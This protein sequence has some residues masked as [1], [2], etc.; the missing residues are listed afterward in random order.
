MKRLRFQRLQ[1]IQQLDPWRDNCKIARLVAGYE[2]PWDMTKALEIAL[3]RTFC[4]P[5]ISHLLDKT[6]E[7]AVRSQ[8]RYDDTGLIVSSIFKWGHD[9]EQG[10][11]AIARMNRIHSHFPISNEDYLYVLSTFIYEP[12]RWIDRFGWRQLCEVEKQGLFYFWL[13]IGEQ[14]GLQRLPSTYEAFEQYNLAYEAEHFRYSAAAQRVG[15]ATVALFLSWFPSPLRP[16]LRP[17]VYAMLDDGMLAAFGFPAP[18]SLQRRSVEGVLRLR[19][20]LLRYWLPRTRPGF[21]VDE[22]QRSYPK[23]YQ[24]EDIGPPTLIARLNRTPD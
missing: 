18:G 12:I 14:M 11:A 17:L 21:Y 3:L 10:K 22:P 5:S 24:L 15:E 7:F 19:S 6:G 23:G 2:F 20:H 9:S 1:V 8:K 16:T 4:V 13:C